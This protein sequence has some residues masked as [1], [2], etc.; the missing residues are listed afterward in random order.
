MKFRRAFQL[1]CIITI[2]INHSH[3][4]AQTSTPPAGPIYIVTSGDLLSVIA[5]TFNVRPEDIMAAN[6]ISDPN[7]IYPGDQLIIPGLEGITGTLTSRV[8][9]FGD[10]QS[11]ISR[12]YRIPMGILRKLNRIISPTEFYAGANLVV[13]QDPDKPAW[14]GSS[15]LGSGE[16][17]LELS[18][19]QDTDPWTV[20]EINSLPG[21]WGALPGDVLYNPG[22][23]AEAH[24]A[25]LP[26]AFLS[27]EVEPLPIVQGT[28][29]QIQVNTGTDITLSGI[30]VDHELHFFP[31]ENGLQVA[32]QGV[33]TLTEPGLYPLRLDATLPDGSIQSFEQMILIKTDYYS[34]EILYVNPIFID[35]VITKPEDDLIRSLTR[36][37]TPQRF[38]NGIFESPASQ[39]E[40]TSTLASKFG[41]RRT[42]FG[43]GTDLEV[44][45]FHSGLDFGGGTGLPITAPAPG[46]VVFAGPLDIRG[47]ATIINHGWGVYSGIWHQSEFKV[48]AG[49]F[50][51]TGQVIGLVGGTGRVTGAHLH[52]E[53]W[54]NGIQVNPIDWLE[55][56]YPH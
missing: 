39:Y 49:D 41:N 54:V 24:Q 4:N 10:S 48:Q 21:T 29:A 52:W 9:L 42:Y 45:G 11:S 26:Y 28:T 2:I 25:G 38:W 14:S 34:T 22:T 7:L 5:A 8:V 15:N 17:L 12:Q 23:D 40:S 1:I 19:L 16:T 50:V 35:P 3:T 13:L 51:E 18:I 20:S 53:I 55:T 32:L 27:A 46:I 36:E 6:N 47:N 56:I 44:F 37:A 30:L 31:L 43:I 33:H